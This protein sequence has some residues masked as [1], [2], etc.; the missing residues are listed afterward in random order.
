MRDLV[1]WRRSNETYENYQQL[2]DLVTATIAPT[3]WDEVGG[4]GAIH[5][6]RTAAAI[7]ISQT[8]EVHEQIAS[9]WR[10]SAEP[11]RCSG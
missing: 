11:A 4:P 3:T 6:I 1:T 10:L 2:I 8:R 5:E 9:L 7:V